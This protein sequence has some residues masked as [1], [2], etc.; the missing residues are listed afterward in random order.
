MVNFAIHS[1]Q[2]LIFLIKFL[3]PYIYV[4]FHTCPTKHSPICKKRAVLPITSILAMEQH[5]KWILCVQK[6][7]EQLVLVSPLIFWRMAANLPASPSLLWELRLNPLHSLLTWK[8]AT[9]CLWCLC[10]QVRVNKAMW[11]DDSSEPLSMLQVF[12]CKY[13]EYVNTR[14]LF[15]TSHI[16]AIS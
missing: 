8:S 5:G 6:R 1:G 15:H 4:F 12:V 7:G 2:C 11:A 9:E 10:W 14:I 16:S 3:L 13:P